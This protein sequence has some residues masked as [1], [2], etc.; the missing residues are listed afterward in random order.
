[1]AQVWEEISVEQW[2][3]MTPPKTSGTTGS[4]LKRNQIPDLRMFK[5]RF[6][7]EGWLSNRRFK[8][9]TGAVRFISKLEKQINRPK[10]TYSVYEFPPNNWDSKT[11]GVLAMPCN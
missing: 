8:T 2:E 1:M 7:Q 3:S 5:R 10:V 11:F 9:R 4:G 6:R